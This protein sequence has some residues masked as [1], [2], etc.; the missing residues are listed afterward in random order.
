MRS[1]MRG[2]SRN[3]QSLKVC[4]A[5]ASMMV[6]AV[7]VGQSLEPLDLSQPSP[8]EEKEVPIGTFVLRLENRAPGAEYQLRWQLR[9]DILGPPLQFLAGEGEVSEPCKEF[10]TAIGK[11]AAETAETEVKGLVKNVEN[12]RPGCSSDVLRDKADKVIAH[13]TEERTVAI[14]IYDSVLEVTVTNLT[15]DKEW[16]AIYRAPSSG[17][18]FGHYGFAF[19][20]SEDERFFVKTID[21]QPGKFRITEQADNQE[22]DFVPAVL[23]SYMPA[24]WSHRYTAWSATGGLGFDLSNPVVFLGGSLAFRQN[25]LLVA[26]AVWHEEMHLNGRYKDDD[27]IGENLSEDQ[28]SETTYDIAWFVGVSFRFDTA[29]LTHKKE[30]TPKAPPKAEEK[31]TDEPPSD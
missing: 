21:D 30:T 19:V 12:L 3:G 23:F 16:N 29:P 31:E 22:F 13:T 27:V 11:L 18:W 5:L 10:D 25:L 8:E 7:V 24:R 2:A 4:I 28:L 17:E 20:P 15:T 26:G 1:P 14:L 9:K 6:P